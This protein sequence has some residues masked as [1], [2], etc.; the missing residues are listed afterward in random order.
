MVLNI[1]LDL[2]CVNLSN[3][4]GHVANIAVTARECVCHCITCHNLCMYYETLSAVN[5]LHYHLQTIY[6]VCV[7]SYHIGF[8]R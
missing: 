6:L 5:W 4:R 2:I 3:L 8:N 7:V 1:D